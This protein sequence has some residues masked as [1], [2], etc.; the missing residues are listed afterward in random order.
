MSTVRVRF[1]QAVYGS[2]AF[3]DRGYALLAHS[4]GCRPEWLAGFLIACQRYGEPRGGAAEAPGLFALRLER[5]PWI[6]VGVSPQGHD[7]RGRPGA[8][9]FHA[10]FVSARDYR[11]AGHVPFGLSGALRGDWTAETRTLPPGTWPVEVPGTPEAP[12]DPRA[13]RIAAALAH[14]G[15]VALEEAGPIDALAREV[16]HALPDR[17]RRRATV[18]TWAFGNGNRFDLVALPRLA[19]VELDPSYVDPATL[20]ADPDPAAPTGTRM[21]LPPWCGRRTIYA[22]AAGAILTGVLL[23]LALHADDRDDSRPAPTASTVPERRPR[24]TTIGDEAPSTPEERRRVA[25]ALRDMAERFG[26]ISADAARH[27]VD[28]TGLMVLLA[29][30]LRYRGPSLSADERTRLGNERGPGSGHERSLALRW[31]AHIRRFA[32]DRPLPADF[33]RRTLR[34]QLATLC[35]SFHLDDDPAAPRRSPAETPHALADALAVDLP[36]RATP[37]SALYPALSGYIEFLGQLPRR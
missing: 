21:W 34:G 12:H 16:W 8:L 19:G 10:L 22:L 33:A 29:R 31:H 5:G 18:A 3:W 28:P 37:L 23:G 13:L 11:K 26:V 2:F 4:P 14:G 36:V 1:E 20:D 30:T 6:V 24:P 25:V 17:A 7:D 27:D 15:R 35:W 9:A 32:D